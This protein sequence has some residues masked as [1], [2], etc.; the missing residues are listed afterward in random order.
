MSGL[1]FCPIFPQLRPLLDAAW[2]GHSTKVAR[3]H[4]LQVTVAHWDQAVTELLTSPKID[5]TTGSVTGGVITARPG[6]SAVTWSNLE[7]SKTPCLMGG[8]GSELQSQ[9]PRQGSNLWPQL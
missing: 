6:P 8:D 9:Y 5:T 7:T 2:P 1:R 4:Y 3:K